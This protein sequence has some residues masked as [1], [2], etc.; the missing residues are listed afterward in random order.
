MLVVLPA[1]ILS[2]S[3][4]DMHFAECIAMDRFMIQQCVV[5]CVATMVANGNVCTHGDTASTDTLCKS[6]HSQ[7]TH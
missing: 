5:R 3:R 1:L 4:C 7:H 2:V 6:Q